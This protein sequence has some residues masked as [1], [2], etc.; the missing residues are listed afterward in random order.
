MAPQNPSTRSPAEPN[1]P[2]QNQRSPGQPQQSGGSRQSGG[3][4]SSASWFFDSAQ[5][6]AS[7]AQASNPISGDTW[8]DWA[9]RLRNVEDILTRP[10]LR[11]NAA[12]IMDEARNMRIDSRRNDEP[13]QADHLQ[14]RI[15]KPLM[16]LRDRVAEAIAQKDTQRPQLQL[17]AAPV[18]ERYREQVRRYAEQ[19]GSGQ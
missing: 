10:E 8:N 15:I 3:G 2:P 6:G 16:E 18:P 1:S 4:E 12:R 14:L 19:L 5:D 13:P 7:A 17:D 11:N 9:D